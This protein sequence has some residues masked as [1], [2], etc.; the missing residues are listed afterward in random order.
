[1]SG[2]SRTGGSVS[3]VSTACSCVLRNTKL[4]NSRKVGSTAWYGSKLGERSMA[5]KVQALSAQYLCFDG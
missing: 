2:H 3:I 5:R 4:P 1:M